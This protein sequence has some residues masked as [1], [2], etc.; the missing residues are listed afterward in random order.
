MTTVIINSNSFQ[1]QPLSNVSVQL[2]F[3]EMQDANT[4]ESYHKYICDNGYNVERCKVKGLVTLPAVD[5]EMLTLNLAQLI[6]GISDFGGEFSPL[7]PDIDVVNASNEE[8]DQ[9]IASFSHIGIAFVNQDTKQWFVANSYGMDW[10]VGIGFPMTTDFVSSGS[11]VTDTSE[12]IEEEPSFTHENS[13]FKN[14]FCFVSYRAGKKEFFGGDLTDTNNEPRFYT[15]KKRAYTKALAELTE[16]FN[17][18]TKQRDIVKILDAHNLRVH[19]YC[20]MD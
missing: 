12:A 6:E 2:K 5:F 18:K 9:W 19:T 11:A 20:A 1:V 17:G 15:T 16:K 14:E 8:F 7:L 13:C 4:L 3:S 10:C